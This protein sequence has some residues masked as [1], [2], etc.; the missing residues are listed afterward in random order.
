MLKKQGVRVST[1]FIRF[2]T[3]FTGGFFWS[4]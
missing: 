1:G 3:G 4:R 2:N